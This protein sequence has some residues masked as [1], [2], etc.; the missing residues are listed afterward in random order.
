MGDEEVMATS[1]AVAAQPRGGILRFLGLGKG[2]D[3]EAE[4]KEESEEEEVGDEDEDEDDGDEDED[5]EDEEETSIVEK[6]VKKE[7]FR[8][9]ENWFTNRH[10]F[11]LTVEFGFRLKDDNET[12]EVIHKGLHY[13]GLW[14]F[15][16]VFLFHS[17]YFIWATERYINSP[18]FGNEDLEEQSVRYRRNIPLTTVTEI[19]FDLTED[20]R[21]AREWA[22]SHSKSTQ[23]YDESLEDIKALLLKAGY[24]NVDAIEVNGKEIKLNFKDDIKANSTLRRAMTVTQVGPAGARRGSTLRRSMSLQQYSD[25]AAEKAKATE[26]DINNVLFELTSDIRDARDAENEDGGA[27]EE[28]HE[29]E[30]PKLDLALMKR[31]S[32]IDLARP[33]VKEESF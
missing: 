9:L 1:A 10:L 28:E 29:A 30:K 16:F 24:S 15:Y 8:L 21:Q 14:P 6:F 20:I 12:V 19:L 5:E 26:K 27:D 7:R 3:G 4:E 33:G 22:K 17:M 25:R 23:E 18:V 2:A 11:D 31:M 32:H 13:S